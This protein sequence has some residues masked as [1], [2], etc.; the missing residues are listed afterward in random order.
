MA[1]TRILVTTA[2]LAA[3]SGS[4]VLAIDVARYYKSQGAEVTIATNYINPIIGHAVPDGIHLIDDIEACELSSFDLVWCQHSL[5][6][7]YRCESLR[8]LAVAGKIPLVA[9][10]TL[11]RRERLEAVDITLAKVLG[12]PIICNSSVTQLHTQRQ[13]GNSPGGSIIS[14]N[15]A[16]LDDFWRVRAVRGKYPRTSGE[17]KHLT[18]ISNHPPPE[19]LEALTLLEE[20]G[21][22]VRRIGRDHEYNL[23]DPTVFERTD[24]VVSIGRSVHF[25]LAAGVPAYVYDHFGGDGWLTPSNVALNQRYNFTGRPGNRRLHASAIV[26]E[27]WNGYHAA[28]RDMSDILATPEVH[29]LRLEQWLDEL[30]DLAMDRD[31]QR[32]RNDAARRVLSSR[33]VR[34]H[35]AVL[36]LNQRSLRRQSRG[37]HPIWTAAADPLLQAVL[38][39]SKGV[40]DGF[41]TWPPAPARDSASSVLSDVTD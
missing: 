40:L 5:V 26:S 21:V 20:A 7:L 3:F 35:L 10:V 31:R 23:V 13:F 34:T 6:G 37:E 29:D 38:K 25:A 32:L 39:V 4:E 1:P 30:L 2:H 24:A 41:A 19:L 15:N 9:L 14:F 16:S 11:S 18:A 12:G 17:L 33:P 22:A 36:R 28:V 27:I 8:A